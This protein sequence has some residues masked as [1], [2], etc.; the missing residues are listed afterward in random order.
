MRVGLAPYDMKL[1][2]QC[3]GTTSIRGFMSF[4]RVRG[5]GEPYQPEPV[6]ARRE[7]PAICNG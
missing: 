1:D 2:F 7:C 4:Q 5:S 6:V 3:V